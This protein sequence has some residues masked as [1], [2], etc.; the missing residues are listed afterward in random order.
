M[1]KILAFAAL[2]GI[3]AAGTMW[4]HASRNTF[5]LTFSD[6][7]ALHDAPNDDLDANFSALSQ[8]MKSRA[9]KLND[10]LAAEKM[11]QA[12]RSDQRPILSGM[13]DANVP[14][15][16]QDQMRDDLGFI[17]SIKGTGASELH[18]NIFGMV[19]GQ[20][21]MTF[22]AS[23]VKAIGLDSCGGPKAV[24]CVQP[25]KNHSKMWLTPNYT[26]FNHPQITR[27][28]IVFHESRHTEI[29]HDFW[30]HANC[31][32]PFKD[33]KGDDM[34][35]IFTGATLAGEDACDTT[36]LGSY[37]SSLIMLKNIQKFC[38]NCTDKIK[39]DAGIYADDQVGRITGPTAKKQIREDLY[40]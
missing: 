22:F 26:K 13:F 12:A 5:S 33:A 23:R 16:L 3:A 38:A 32:D 25:Y 19:D 11:A 10:D 6:K 9:K 14:V 4:H 24:A 29:I 27:M 2:T 39:M 20:T 15:K 35:S 21:Y 1:K 18:K 40:E 17:Q 7:K 31:P 37:G 34:I 28:M 36:P 30:F 8:D